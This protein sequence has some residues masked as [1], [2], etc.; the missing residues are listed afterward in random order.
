VAWGH[1]STRVGK[2][3]DSGGITGK[4]A[5]ETGGFRRRF[6]PPFSQDA[7]PS[8][9]ALG[10]PEPPTDLRPRDAKA[11]SPLPTED[12][13]IMLYL[14]MPSPISQAGSLPAGSPLVQT[15]PSAVPFWRTAL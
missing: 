12:N 13:T 8:H 14:I 9:P 4:I 3:R 5:A 15:P 11:G 7:E 1:V 6:K 10:K 2:R